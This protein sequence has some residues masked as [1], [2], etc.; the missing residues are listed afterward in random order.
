CIGLLHCA[1]GQIDVDRYGRPIEDDEF[2]L[3]L[4]AYHEPIDFALPRRSGAWRP[5]VDTAAEAG[6]WSAPDA[7]D[8]R[9]RLEP[10][11]L[12]LLRLEA[13]R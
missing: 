10:R 1:E 6:G 9:Y 7:A 12:A 5:V 13:R 4:N 11:S 2:L 3:L 8:G